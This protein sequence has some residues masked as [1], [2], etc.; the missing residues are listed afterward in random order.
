MQQ[1]AQIPPCNRGMTRKIVANRLS[2]YCEWKG[3]LPEVQ[4]GFRRGRST[5][6]MMFVVRRLQELAREKNLP[7]YVCFVDLQKAYDSVDRSLL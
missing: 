1:V 5:V 4:C 2:A 7:V 3:I 6:D